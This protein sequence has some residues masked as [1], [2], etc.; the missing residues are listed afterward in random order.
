MMREDSV[1][2]EFSKAELASLVQLMDA[3]LKALGLTHAVVAAGLIKKIEAAANAT[4]IPQNEN[5]P[6]AAE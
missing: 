3:G 6:Q 1:T 2:L 4:S 5:I